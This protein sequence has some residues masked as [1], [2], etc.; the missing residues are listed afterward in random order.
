V[1]CSRRFAGHM[2][3]YRQ[4]SA[5]MRARGWQAAFLGPWTG[6][7]HSEAT[8]VLGAW[9]ASFGHDLIGE[10]DQ[11]ANEAR[12]CST[13]HVRF[14]RRRDDGGWTTTRLADVPATIFSEVM[15]DVDLFVAVAAIAT[16]PSDRRTARV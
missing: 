9:R 14:E 13:E 6:G 10:I 5:L 8:R 7:G 11:L 16:D 15:R 4:A 12:Y 2:L 1:G 3:R